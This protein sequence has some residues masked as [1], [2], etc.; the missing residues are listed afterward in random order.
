[1]RLYLYLHQFNIV[2]VTLRL[3]LAMFLGAFIGMERQRK[4]YAAGLR[5]HI[6]VCVGATLTVL[7]GQYNF[8]M[9]NTEWAELA[10]KY[11]L[12]VDISRY[13]AQVINGIGFLGAGN[14]IVNRNQEVKGL[15]TA[16]SL[17]ASGCMGVVI[18]AGFYECMFLAFIMIL[19]CNLFLSRLS[20]Y[21]ADSSP[22]MNVFVEYSYMSDL[23]VILGGIKNMGIGIYDVD[24]DRGQRK[25]G[26]N[27]SAV[28]MLNLPDKNNHNDVMEAIM[29]LDNVV[30]ADEI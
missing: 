4:G 15:T 8:Y 16:A 26:I 22:N 3:V 2:S 11:K 9:L 7:I 13:S 6:F 20:S 27:P 29:Q 25:R 17:W 19:S 14:I 18:G 5:T 12:G 24:I 10:H 28:L 23:R 21:I 1:M 30:F